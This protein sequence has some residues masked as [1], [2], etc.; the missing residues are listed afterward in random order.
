MLH[1]F[2]TLPLAFAGPNL[3]GKS[4]YNT[5]ENFQ[6]TGAAGVPTVYLGLLDFMASSQETKLH[7]LKMVIVGGAACPRKIF[8]AFDR[9]DLPSCC[10]SN[11]YAMYSAVYMLCA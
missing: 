10:F 2:D 1:L 6:V 9:W 4:I 5:L 11:V 8:D 7:H 3:D